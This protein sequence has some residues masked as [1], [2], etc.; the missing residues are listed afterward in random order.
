MVWTSVSIIW[1]C[2]NKVPRT[3]WLHNRPASFLT[4]LGTW[5][6]KS[7]CQQAM[8]HLKPV[9]K[10]LSLASQF[11]VV[12]VNP[13]ILFA[14]AIGCYVSSLF[15]ELHPKFPL[16][17]CTPIIW[18]YSLFN[19]LRSITLHLQIHYLQF[20]SYSV[21]QDPTCNLGLLSI[22]TCNKE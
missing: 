17:I 9:T 16:L 5:W 12:A 11:L 20:K 4:I 18:N 13:C 19:D 8:L 2:H 15:L 10:E 7:V 21:A 14:A 1:C 3:R 6:L 22:T